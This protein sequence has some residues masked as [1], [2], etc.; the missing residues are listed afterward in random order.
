MP[1]WLV[2]LTSAGVAAL[3]SSLGTLV[4]QRFERDARRRGR[5]LA[6][7]IELAMG[8]SRLLA[9]Q[10]DKC[11]R[12]IVSE[13]DILLAEKYHRWLLHVLEYQRL[14][15]ALGGAHRPQSPR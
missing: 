14:A 12:S 2:V 4:G 10:A 15:R 11:G 1:I 13:D 3:V 7:S 6:K 8:R 5:L 9:D